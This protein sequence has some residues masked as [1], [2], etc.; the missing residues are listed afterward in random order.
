MFNIRR[1]TLLTLIAFIATTTYAQ[2]NGNVSTEIPESGLSGMQ[3]A[4][5]PS[6]KCQAVID[7]YKISECLIDP[8]IS[9]TRPIRDEDAPMQKTLCS[10]Q[11]FCGIKGVNAAID[12]FEKDCAGELTNLLSGVN[13]AYGNWFQLPYSY[14]AQCTMVGGK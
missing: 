5:E 3:S 6:E 11:D 12:A 4:L 14:A 13:Q 1:L 10:K 9:V 8:D 2:P 7:K